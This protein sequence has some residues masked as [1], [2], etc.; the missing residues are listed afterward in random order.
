M[1]KRGQGRRNYGPNRSNTAERLEKNTRRNNKNDHRLQ[2]NG[3]QKIK[4]I[5]YKADTDIEIPNT[6]KQKT[7]H[8]RK[9]SIYY[10]SDR[11]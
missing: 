4:F 9:E 6:M 2:R 11:N 1:G 7:R 3:T 10:N 8:Q 5:P